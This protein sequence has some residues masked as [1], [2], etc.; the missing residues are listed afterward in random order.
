MNI[1][2]ELYSLVSRTVCRVKSGLYKTKIVKPRRAPLPVVSV[3]NIGLG[4]SEKTPLV[5]ELLAYLLGRGLKPALV[6]RGYKGNWEKTGGVLSDGRTLFGTWRESGDEPFMIARDFPQAG[7]FIGKR[8]YLSSLRAKD[9]G[10]RVIVLDDAFQHLKLRR[11]LDIVLLNSRGRRAL[12]EGFP[13]LKRA[14]ILLLKKEGRESVKQKV[15]KRFPRLPLFEYTVVAK[16]LCNP[17]DNDLFPPALLQGKKVLALCGIAGPE[18]FFSLLEN[19]GIHAAA[20]LSFPDHYPYPRR[21]L[22]RIA[23]VCRRHK[24]DALITT[25]KDAV[26]L[27]GRLE[28]FTK[29]PFYFLK[30]GLD[31]PP[32]FFETVWTILSPALE[33]HA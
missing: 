21:A 30:I 24:P 8:R 25:E 16:G 2:L 13:A 31:L 15:Q 4:G 28:S 5:M 1:F 6:T 11:D 14:D 10:F 3:G 18:R 17:H 12:R 32:P 9:M 26:K 7:V 27:T 20:R 22:D 19:Q 29:L 23:A 33:N